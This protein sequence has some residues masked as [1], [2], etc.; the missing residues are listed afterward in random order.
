MG[1]KEDLTEVARYDGLPCAD[2]GSINNISVYEKEDEDGVKHYDGN[3]W[4]VCSAE[5]SGFKSAKWLD[6]NGIL[7]ELGK[8]RHKVN[9]KENKLD[10][11]ILVDEIKTYDSRGVRE[12]GI[13]KKYAEMYQMRVGYD[14]TTGDICEHYY[15]VTKDSE[16]TGYFKRELP[17]KFSAIGDVKDCE[18]QGQHLFDKG[19]EY[20]NQTNK[21]FLVVTEGFLDMLAAQQML[22]ELTPKDERGEP[23]YMTAVVS[24]PNGINSKAIKTNY[25]FLN[26]YENVIFCVDQ[27]EA[28]SKGVKDLCKSLPMGKA[29]TMS[30][31][32]KDPC[33]MLKAKLQ[34][35]FY[36][37]FW[38]AESYSPAGIVDGAGLWGTLTN[39]D[40]DN[41]VKYPW[42]GLNKLTGGIRTSEVVTLTAGS[43]IAKSTFARKILSHLIETT[44]ANIGGMFLEESVKRTGLSIMSNSANKLLHLPDTQYT[45]EEFKAAFDATLGT[46]RVFLYDHFGSTDIDTIVENI[47]YFTRAANCKYIFLDHI[48]IMVSGGDQGDER[49]ALDEIMTKLR[50]IVQELD[51]CLIIVSHLKRPSGD[52]GHEQGAMTSLAQLRG[53]AA[54]AQLSDIVIG[55]ER[56]QQHDDDLERNTST[57]RVLKNRFCGLTGVATRLLYNH[58][59]G[60]IVERDEVDENL[61]DVSEFFA[62]EGSLD[63]LPFDIMSEDLN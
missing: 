39:V 44:D 20:E 61:D 4:G 57:L 33:D 25:R 9:S 46:G 52:L 58:S 30:F 11:Q 19:G 45:P 42:E 16:I 34:K 43:G 59:T 55:I 47:T 8:E 41:S 7:D 60:A 37:A 28:G 48:S 3:C 14:A 12:R 35:E 1:V 22:Q 15:P 40:E 13:K 32:K 18:L 29:K 27:D 54:I 51:I 53:S 5:G 63:D 62:D 23:K 31:S 38:Q 10:Q 50:T 56:N 36:K 6:E 2:C 26:Q 17:K 21:K 24:L 49:K